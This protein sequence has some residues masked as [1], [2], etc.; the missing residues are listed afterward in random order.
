MPILNYMTKH[1]F[2]RKLIVVFLLGVSSGLPFLLILSTLSVW[3]T[4]VGITKT[5]IGLLAWVT[6]PY[7]L[8]FA[9]SH[10]FDRIKLPV[11]TAIFGPRKAWLLVIQILLM[12]SIIGISTSE[13]R[14]GLFYL[15]IWAFCIGLLSACQDILIEGFRIDTIDDS[16]TSYG[17]SASVIGY[18]IGMLISSAGALYLS[19]IASWQGVY[20][21][22]S[23]FILIGIFATICLEE[24]TNK[25]TI[26]IINNHGNT[27]ANLF[28]LP[29]KVLAK[30]DGWVLIFVFMLSFKA[31]DTI[32]HTMSMPFLIELGFSKVE[33]A[34]V[35]KTFGILAMIIGGAIGGIAFTKYKLRNIFLKCMFMQVVACLFFMLQ[36]TYGNNMW[37]L[38]ITMGI[39]NF[40]CGISQVALIYYLTLLCKGSLSATI[41]AFLT[42][43]ASFDRVII[44]MGAGWLADNLSWV[45]FFT[46]SS[47]VSLPAIFILF[48]YVEHFE[49]ISSTNI[50]KTA[51]D[52]TGTIA[53]T[54]TK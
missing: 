16:E 37:L 43:I 48:R 36:A 29:L 22:M 41:F 1:Y 10:I 4:E 7:T 12:G 20:I 30:K 19:S 38:F 46:V 27:F 26:K 35:A 44:A 17:A 47:L 25:D 51:N 34:H 28:L 13:P 23:M 31:C 8:K 54:V 11:L 32:L 24:K 33:I 3:L 50:E 2:S 15:S 39:E 52:V 40:A 53:S 21:I 5:H 49:N 42:S 18:R 9:L 6:L 14:A 45:G